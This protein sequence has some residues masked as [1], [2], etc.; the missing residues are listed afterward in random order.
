MRVFEFVIAMMAAVSFVGC[1]VSIH[2]L[3]GSVSG[4]Q[5]SGVEMTEA[6]EIEDFDSLCLEG[7][8]T[9]TISVGQE[10]SLTVTTDD[11]LVELI[12]TK[13]EGGVLKI[14][15]TESINAK[16]GLKFDIT[17]PSLK[18]IEV[19]GAA[20]ININ[21]AAGDELLIEISGA[22]QLN[23]SGSVTNLDVEINGAGNVSLSELES[24]NTT[25]EISGAGSAEVFASQSVNAEISGTGSIQ[26]HGNP[27]KVQKEVN[28]IGSIQIVE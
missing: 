26:V 14:K 10:T 24:E 3:V 16:S 4:V 11:N 23:G 8:G 2:G 5:G 22:G 27:A 12:E 20:D 17:T 25:I 6:R 19:A 13:V 28:G 18:R 21:D 15:P 9:V 7:H 1:N